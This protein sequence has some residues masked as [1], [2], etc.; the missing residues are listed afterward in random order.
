[1]EALH[2]YALDEN[3]NRASG[4]IN[5]NSLLWKR[6]YHEPGT[7]TI[8]VPR[9]VYDV[10]WAYICCDERPEVGVIQKPSYADDV[11]SSKGVDTVTLSGLFLEDRMN[12]FVF[13]DERSEDAN[14]RALKPSDIRY[15][16]MFREAWQSSGGFIYTYD[17]EGQLSGYNPV[18][19]IRKPILKVVHNGDGTLTV[20]DFDNEQ[21]VVHPLRP[22]QY[23]QL[24][25]TFWYFVDDDEGRHLF[26]VNDEGEDAEHPYWVTDLYGETWVR[27]GG[28]IGNSRWYLVRGVKEKEADGY[29]Y[30]LES[31]RH[32]F[33]ESPQWESAEVMGPYS[34][35][36]AGDAGRFTEPVAQMVSWVR[37][38]FQDGMTYVK[39]SFE[40]RRR[41]IDPSM[42]RLGDMLYD[43]LKVEGASYRLRYDFRQAEYVFEVYRGL[44][45]T[46]DQ[47]VN[48][49]ATFSDTW[50]TMIGYRYEK[51]IS[52]YRNKC[53]VLY[54]YE[55]PEWDG[56][57][58]RVVSFE[59]TE[60]DKTETWY[61]IPYERKHGVVVVRK[62]DGLEDA[63][64][65]LDLR[66]KK[67]D[68]DSAWKREESK[69]RPEFEGD[70]RGGYLE[71]ADFDGRGRALLENDYSII[72]SLDAGMLDQEGYLTVWDMGDLVDFAVHDMGIASKARITGVDEA[73]SPNSASVSAI[74]GDDLLTYEQRA[75]LL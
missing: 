27:T 51:D 2:V 42:K 39:P 69:T 1:M 40:G 64:V 65:Y 11:A 52:N 54:D 6:R 38:F 13:L 32:R 8:E 24:S 31:W 68:G 45:R 5:Y 41:V 60:G 23:Q 21:Y 28:P 53:F 48:P 47:T 57:V 43:N 44:D 67:P 70:I 50:G 58:P 19:H 16:V 7:F 20:D 25:G 74:I 26:S 62:D 33:D 66:D 22:E 56:N 59:K 37:L 75:S 14:Q 18:E 71:F 4:I 3:M 36:E 10:N 30:E 61:R 35:L 17:R 55:E 72:E 49:W 9:D 46:Q 15:K 12:S 34:R 63:E 73:Y 29:I